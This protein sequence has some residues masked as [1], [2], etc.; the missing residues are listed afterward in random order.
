MAEIRHLSYG[1][2]V[3][4]IPAGLESVKFPE[5]LGA[6][7]EVVLGDSNHP[8]FEKALAIE[9][10]T[11][12]NLGDKPV[13]VSGQDDEEFKVYDPLSTFAF[14]FRSE[15]PF[16][17]LNPDNLVGMT[18]FI[19]WSSELGNK[20]VADL[21]RIPFTTGDEETRRKILDAALSPTDE[22]SASAVYGGLITKLC[23]ENGACK[24]DQV[25][26][27]ATL[28]PSF[29]VAKNV[30]MSV[31]SALLGITTMYL[32][33]AQE[34]LIRTG[35]GLNY[36]TQFT[37]ERLHHMMAK[38]GYPSSPVAG[39]SGVLYDTNGD[40]I[41]MRADPQI[42]HITD[43]RKVVTTAEAGSHFGIIRDVYESQ[44]LAGL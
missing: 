29:E 3:P 41:A 7:I 19:P 23:A 18:R 16:S 10:E 36:F 8:A 11:F 17:K 15:S 26:D 30:R 44:V 28:A 12:V 27:V 38:L 4:Y 31:N 2:R 24:E 32:L 13:E 34:E 39:I 6:S 1:P 5:F 20:T 35:E 22:E 40:G 42:T 33:R 9:H 14:A 37:D 25:M 43:L 21:S